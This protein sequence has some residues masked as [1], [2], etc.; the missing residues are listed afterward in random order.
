LEIFKQIF[1]FLGYPHKDLP[2]LL[3]I[4]YKN[5][6]FSGKKSPHIRSGKIEQ[7]KQ[8]FTPALQT[9]FLELYGNALQ[10]LGYEKTE[11]SWQ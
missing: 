9:R 6:L 1:I 10:R 3:K 11:S 2:Q 7:W 4:A 5:S 8:H